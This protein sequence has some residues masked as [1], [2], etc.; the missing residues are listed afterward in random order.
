MHKHNNTIAKLNQ[1]ILG[2][3]DNVSAA[4]VLFIVAYIGIE[5]LNFGLIWSFVSVAG[6]G[7][8]GGFVGAVVFSVLMFGNFWLLIAYKTKGY[9]TG[10]LWSSLILFTLSV[11]GLNLFHAHNS[12]GLVLAGVFPLI[13]LLAGL[14]SKDT[15]GHQIKEQSNLTTID[16]I[17][18][19]IHILFS[20]K[21]QLRADN[22]ATITTL[23]NQK[24]PLQ[25][26]VSALQGQAQQAGQRVR[27]L[28]AEASEVQ[29]N[30]GMPDQMWFQA[31][32]ADTLV[33]TGYTQTAAGK[34]V[35]ISESTVRNRLGMLN[36]ESLRG[37][38]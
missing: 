8:V 23:Q 13:T 14:V 32:Q 10:L 7:S 6:Y 15:I 24:S 1:I 33:A 5:Y 17:E 20:R 16:T 4:L 36:G 26:E 3:G 28:R 30:V 21:T 35:G 18:E 12:A 2:A 19:Q 9:R 22:S 27:E 34:A 31:I 29:A 38:L 37:K 25:A 11:A